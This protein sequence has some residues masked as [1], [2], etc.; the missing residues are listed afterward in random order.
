[1]FVATP[2]SST[3]TRSSGRSPGAAS[4]HVA[5]AAATSSRACSAATWLICFPPQREPLARPAYGAHAGAPPGGGAE[6]VGQLGERGGGLRLDQVLD[7]LGPHFV[8][9]TARSG[10]HVV[11]VGIGQ[12]EREHVDVDAVDAAARALLDVLAT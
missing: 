6:P 3:N 2:L 11:R 5:R 9:L 1:M 7:L 4:R 10:G 8:S 12:H